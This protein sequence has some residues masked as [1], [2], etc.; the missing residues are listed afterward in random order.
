MK[1]K[2]S[3]RVLEFANMVSRV[4]GL[5]RILKPLYY[6]YK[7]YVRRKRNAVFHKNALKLLKEFD[8][9]CEEN[10]ISYSLAFGTMLGAVREHGFIKH[11]IDIDVFIRIEDNN[12]GIS[13]LLEQNG[14]KL[15]HLFLVENG[16]LGREET[17]CKH[18]VLIDVF[19]I[20]P[21]VD[22]LSYTCDFKAY[23]GM[24]TW[25]KSQKVK[26]GVLARR[27]EIPISKNTIKM[28]FEDLLLP[29]PDNYDEFLRFRYGDSYMTPDPS[30]YNGNNPHIIEWNEKKAIF[31][32]F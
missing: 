12:E 8:S 19:Y 20:F 5:K 9:C 3:H 11:D 32:E 22:V 7:S 1:N 21:P 28:K 31:K 29:V 26:G 10:G 16:A 23:Q 15:D 17:Y 2:I 14:F 25:Q 4:P 13:K 27:I 30:W 24:V 6:P 18:D